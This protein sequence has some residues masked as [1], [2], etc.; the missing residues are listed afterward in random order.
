MDWY[1]IV[2]LLGGLA[3]LRAGAVDEFSDLVLLTSRT[4]A[5]IRVFRRGEDDVLIE[6]GWFIEV[7]IDVREEGYL[8]EVVTAILDGR[9]VEE[10]GIAHDGHPRAIAWTITYPGGCLAASLDTDRMAGNSV[11]RRVVPAWS[12]NSSDAS[13]AEVDGRRSG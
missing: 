12:Q 13:P 4:G 3:R 1:K 7:G 2:D 5:R 11:Y 8:A 9:A 10:I 6:A